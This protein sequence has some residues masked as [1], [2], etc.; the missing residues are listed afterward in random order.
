MVQGAVVPAFRQT[1]QRGRHIS[2][3]AMAAHFHEEMRVMMRSLI[4]VLVLASLALP[5][6]GQSLS[7]S[8][9]VDPEKDTVGISPLIYGSNGQSSD[10]DANITAR[11]L[12]GNR[13]TGYNWE[14][15]ASNMGSD[16]DAS[17]ANDNYMTWVMGIPASKENVPG[18]VLT[19]FHDT[20]IAM[21]AIPS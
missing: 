6:R 14:N 11:R 17:S 13:M 19:S 1:Q 4:V 2:S 3:R 21:G 15:N 20:S 5:A 12:G 7:V 9:D 10:W 18:I 16:Y 8:F